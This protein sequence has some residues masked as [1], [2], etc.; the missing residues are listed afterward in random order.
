MPIHSLPSDNSE[1]WSDQDLYIVLKRMG[2]AFPD[3][4]EE[5]EQFLQLLKDQHIPL[6]DNLPAAGDILKNG[7]IRMT[8]PMDDSINLEI[9]DYLQQAAREGGDISPEVRKRM[10]EDRKKSEED[11]DH[12]QT[13]QL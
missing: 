7:F 6:L 8:S 5:L 10:E 13:D 12:D 9:E 2:L 1:E 3:T 11:Q 4:Q